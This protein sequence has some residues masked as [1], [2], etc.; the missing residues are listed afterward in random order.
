MRKFNKS[1]LSVEN[2]AVGSYSDPVDLNDC[3]A[4]SIQPVWEVGVIAAV[5]AI[6]SS[7]AYINLTT[8]VV[9]SVAHGLVTGLKVAAA[10][11]TDPTAV[12]AASATDV[13]IT[14]DVIVK[15]NTFFDGLAVRATTSDTLPTGISAGT[16]YYVGECTADQFSLYDS[17]AHAVAGGATG[18]I[19]IEDV[20]VG[21]QT[22]TPYGAAALP[23]GLS[24][25]NY[26]VIKVTDD[27][28]KLSD[29]KAHAIAG[30]NVIDI[31]AA[32]NG[33]WKL[34]PAAIASGVIHLEGSNDGTNYFD[35]ASQT[36]DV[37]TNSTTVLYD[38]N[39]WYAM[40]RLNYSLTDGAINVDATMNL[41]T[42]SAQ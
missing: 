15:A 39:P 35:I 38:E 32:G 27:T 30:T 26:W 29:S 13:N 22:L 8:N 3:A 33:V 16:T 21:N 1:I 5:T 41:E 36:V 28:F 18:L 12:V 10:T 37:T 24:A 20:G 31:T 6:P 7:L 9:T 25:T 42:R 4:Y 17:A 14:T 11:D 2:V 23:T 34:T 19:D 40:V